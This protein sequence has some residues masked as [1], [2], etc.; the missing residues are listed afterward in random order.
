[1]R[2]TRRPLI[3]ENSTDENSPEKLL[4]ASE[5]EPSVPILPVESCMVAAGYRIITSN[6]PSTGEIDICAKCLID[7][8]GVVNCEFRNLHYLQLS[9]P[10]VK[11]FGCFK[12]GKSITKARPYNYC[13]SCCDTYDRTSRQ[14]KSA[15]CDWDDNTLCIRLESELSK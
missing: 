11:N 15:R 5:N 8:P 7:T 10:D 6:S 3:P 13:K 9:R 2:D 14:L 12:C 4:R 1:M